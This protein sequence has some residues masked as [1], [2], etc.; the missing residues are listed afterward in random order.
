V[1]LVQGLG[2]G[3]H[4]RIEADAE[5]GPVH[6]VV[7][8]LRHTDDLHPLIGQPLGDGQRII[9]ADGDQRRQPQLLERLLHALHVFRAAG[10]VGTRGA[11][12]RA[13]HMQDAADI[14]EVQ[15][16]V[17]G[18]EHPGPAVTDPLH[19]P[20]VLEGAAGDG[21]DS[22]IQ[23]RAVTAPSEHADRSESD[24]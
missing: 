16:Q 15:V 5:I 19:L 9:A 8:G 2:H 3:G 18:S 4:G 23:A 17:V 13:P 20:A 7:H 11:Q 14:D 6:I 22:G 1:Q 21:A 24:G 12:H 10:G